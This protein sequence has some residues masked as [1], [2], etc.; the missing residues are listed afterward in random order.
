VSYSVG[1]GPPIYKKKDNW[2]S[3]SSRDITKRWYGS[4]AITSKIVPCIHAHNKVAPKNNAL[5]FAKEEDIM[6]R[7]FHL[8]NKSYHI[9]SS[10]HF[11]PGHP[12][13][14]RFATQH[15]STIE[16][17][18][19]TAHPYQVQ[20]QQ[21]LKYN[22]NSCSCRLAIAGLGEIMFSG[23]SDLKYTQRVELLLFRTIL[24]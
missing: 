7:Y 4:P 21:W 9:S 3:S 20:V 18:S 10:C 17:A 13:L 2:S 1:A 23:C 8:H 24:Y 11:C 6:E 22:L 14:P 15:Q 12:L 16:V 19:C 5:Q